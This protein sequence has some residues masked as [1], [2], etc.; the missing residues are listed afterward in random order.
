MVRVVDADTYELLVGGRKQ[1]LRLLSMDA[2]ELSQPFGREAADSVR[3]LLPVGQLGEITRTGKTDLYGRVLG[4]VRVPATKAG[5]RLVALDSV[6]V[7]RGWA[8]AYAPGRARP[9]R[10]AEQQQ[11]QVYGRGLWKCGTAEPVP[12][13]VWRGFNAKVKQLYRGGCTW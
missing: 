12:P 3:Q 8:W 9:Q 13:Q 11:A 2:P 7:A 6:L 10:E 1:Q 4:S 5:G